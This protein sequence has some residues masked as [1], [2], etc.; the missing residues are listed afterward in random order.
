MQPI[1][2]VIRWIEK[3][4]AL[5][6]HRQLLVVSGDEQWAH[7]SI[8]KLLEHA[9]SNSVLWFGDHYSH[10][11]EATTNFKSVLG[12]EYHWVIVNG[13]SGLRGN[14]LMALSGCVAKHGI[15]I[16]LCPDM[17]SWH[18]YDDPQ[19]RHRVSYGS[20]QVDFSS[21]FIQWLVR[22][23]EADST[24]SVLTEKTFTG[25]IVEYS[26]LSA[27]KP[28]NFCATAEQAVV[29]NDI[30]KLDK[31]PSGHLV[32]T[33]DRG[34]GKSSALGIASASLQINATTRVVVTASHPS[35]TARLFSIYEE[36]LSQNPLQS[37]DEHRMV[38]IPFDVLLEK[39]PKFDMLFIDEAASIPNRILEQLVEVYPRIIFCT[40]VNGYE[41]SGRGFS[42][43]FKPY[44]Y[45][46]FPDTIFLTMREPIRWYPND[47]LERFFN[48][49]FAMDINENSD[50]NLL[51]SI[52]EEQNKKNNETFSQN[53]DATVYR[54]F[55]GNELIN[56]PIILKQIF[57]LLVDA[58]YQTTPDDFVRMLDDS[59]HRV[60]A[61]FERSPIECGHPLNT[62]SG[63]PQNDK[64]GHPLAVALTVS[65]GGDALNELAEPITMGKR[66]VPGHLT[67]QRLA[68]EY[69]DPKLAT[70]NYLRIVR[71]A[72]MPSA[73]RQS[74]GSSL[75][76]QIELHALEKNFSAVSTSFGITKELL[77]FW[78]NNGYLLAKMGIK[79]DASSGEFSAIMIK[80]LLQKLKQ[81]I[82]IMNQ[83][84]L[85]NIRY[86]QDFRLK[87]LPAE[88]LNQL[89]LRE[90]EATIPE[91]IEQRVTSVIDIFAQ[92]NR[93]LSNSEWYL[94][95]WLR[96]P[97]TYWDNKVL[98]TD[99]GQ[100]AFSFLSKL[101]IKKWTLPQLKNEFRLT[102]KKDIEAHARRCLNI[103]RQPG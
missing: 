46:R 80:P 15:M 61:V 103:L 78:Q 66:R 97:N 93:P 63:H 21:S 89:L 69:S 18:R 55:K 92:G 50:I 5:F 60:H 17:P 4:K 64:S 39:Q 56:Q 100:D 3:R 94:S 27:N 73:R 51:T 30:L 20:T 9:G 84:A 90:E 42:L 29:V 77:P 98:K 22:H 48:Q 1:E 74:L 70:L 62:N 28:D 23:V 16:L 59:S 8:T 14:A 40:T 54:C 35:Q 34:R 33:A 13:F 91:L 31:R 45:H 75:L 102:G 82:S 101:V 72:V 65:E 47:R 6:C 37:S 2:Q 58:H 25:E 38:F 85:A 67:A 88:L 24:V 79:K 71:I 81:D 7:D 44:L 53:R 57:A 32:I 96:F 52:T 83:T 43:R 10:N 11:I 49:V 41:G 86:Q 99:V 68:F 36:I 95:V 76:N 19:I 26:K 12:Q 87:E